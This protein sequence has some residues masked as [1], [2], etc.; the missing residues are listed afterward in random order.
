[1]YGH[2]YF[3]TLSKPIS[4]LFIIITTIVWTL[5]GKKTLKLHIIC[6]LSGRTGYA[7]MVSCPLYGD[8]TVASWKTHWVQTKILS[9]IINFFSLNFTSIEI[10]RERVSSSQSERTLLACAWKRTRG[11]GGGVKTREYW[12]YFLNVLQLFLKS[13]LH[14]FSEHKPVRE[15]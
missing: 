4:L 6:Q 10:E 12:A 11:G 8:S 14:S 3:S 15:T 2:L 5:M 7:P 1:M 13:C 9:L